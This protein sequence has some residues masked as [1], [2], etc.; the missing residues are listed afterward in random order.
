MDNSE[1]SIHK[2]GEATGD[3]RDD[4]P[5]LV[6][7]FSQS[8]YFSEL[9]ERVLRWPIASRVTIERMDHRTPHP[10]SDLEALVAEYPQLEDARRALTKANGA[11]FLV[12]PERH[13]VPYVKSY[14]DQLRGD[15]EMLGRDST[16]FPVVF[17]VVR[18]DGN[19]PPADEELL[20]RVLQ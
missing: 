4:D 17:D 1:P 11:V 10:E 5:P 16:S 12:S 14:L 20:S 15:L 7:Y 6:L 8:G 2:S 18:F 19:A 3:L 9:M 13:R